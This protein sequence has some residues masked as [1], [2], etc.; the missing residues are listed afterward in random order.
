MAEEKNRD[1]LRAARENGEGT[2]SPGPPSSEEKVNLLEE[3]ADFCQTAG[4]YPTAL[5][6]YAQILDLAE[7]ASRSADLMTET[8]MKMGICF[9][10]TGEFARALEVLNLADRTCDRTR[11]PRLAARILIERSKVNSRLGEYAAAEKDA[12]EALALLKQNAISAELAEAFIAIGRVYL[13]KG[14]MI[15]ARET[16]ESALALYR[17]LGDR[18]GMAK[19]NNNL[20]LVAKNRGHLAEAAEY[21]ERALELAREVGGK[22]QIGIRANNL[23]IIE[24]KRGRFDRARVLW[25][26][27]LQI[28]RELGN[29]WE[30]SLGYLNVAHYYRVTREFA[31]AEEYYQRALEKAREKGHRRCEALCHEYFG[32]LCLRRGEPERAETILSEGLGFARR[33]LP[34]GGLDV[35]C[36]ILRRRAEVRIRRDD[37][38]GAYADLRSALRLARQ[39]GDRYEEGAIRR[40]L[41][42]FHSARGRRRHAERHLR[43][44]VSILAQIGAR[45]EEALSATALGELAAARPEAVS[46]AI[47]SLAGAAEAFREAGTPYEAARADMIR[48]ELLTGRG[49]GLAAIELIEKIH[50]DFTVGGTEEDRIRI[51]DARSRADRQ[52]VSSSASESNTLSA[53]NL[54]LQRIQTTRETEERLRLTLELLKEKT[55]ADRLVLALR[56]GGNGNLEPHARAEGTANDRGGALAVARM[57]IR[58]ASENGGKPIYSTSP[59]SDGRFGESGADLSGIGSLL[60]IPLR[61]EEEITGGIYLDRPVGAPAFGQDE[62]DFAVALAAVVVATLRELRTEE[63]RD[64]NLRLKHRFGI[65]DG[66]ERIVTQSPRLL[67][68]IQTLQKLRD[69]TATILLQ[70]E[71]GTGKEMFA[72]AIHKS[73]LRREKLFV[74]VNCAELSEDVL[75]SELFGHRKGAFTDAKASKQGLFERADGGTVFIDE[76]DKASR[77][78][79]D[80]LLRVVDRKEIKPVGSTES[81]SV[82]VRIVCAA[83]KDL[84]EEVENDRFLK[85]L[86]YRLRV[87]AIY[88]PPL[89]ERREDVPILA[90]H[91]LSKHA[92]RAGKRFRGFTPEAVQQLIEYD[93]PGNVRDLEHEIERIVAV[94]AD[95]SV[96]DTGDIATDIVRETVVPSDGTLTEVIEQIE[97]RMIEETLRRCDGNKSKTARCLGIS[98]RGL[99]NKLERYKIH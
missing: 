15:K 57:A 43:R 30:V 91:F 75:E 82:D 68:T 60:A 27:G 24:F 87:V 17:A 8:A 19:C 10:G 61:G 28:F 51:R 11:E 54:L 29:R 42:L 5:E 59:K 22:P 80:T 94:T 32:E 18:E 72:R 48:A 37:L 71:T 73:S 70:G 9:Q 25:E 62:L 81:V 67:K 21:M 49:D 36:E 53:F 1:I 44:S 86:Y 31:K 47:E 98:R 84:R 69:S 63:I 64:E 39:I 99:L 2:G 7:R 45:Y 88:L 92:K 33:A 14:L 13:R 52:I 83:N 74:T 41:G 23:G 77:R 78:F 85:D 96:V 34:E 93:W 16:Y 26:E 58:H 79:Q 95:G 38:G 90:E 89:R 35:A 76:I 66:F 20:A 4:E 40:I 55:N 3:L 65:G 50:D 12:D 97:R 46:E 56:E 6:Y